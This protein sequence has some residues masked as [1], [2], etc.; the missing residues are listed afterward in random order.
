MDLSFKNALEKIDPEV[1]KPV[2][3]QQAS[4]TNKHF[5][6]VAE[7]KG[8]NESVHINEYEGW[9]VPSNNFMIS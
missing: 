7:A 8:K 2:L 5:T 6:K 9:E 1:L 3:R 4:E